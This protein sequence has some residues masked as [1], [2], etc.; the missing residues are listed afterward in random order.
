MDLSQPCPQLGAMASLALKLAKWLV[1]QGGAIGFM[2]L[3]MSRDTDKKITIGI[4]AAAALSLGY[5]I[6]RFISY[7]DYRSRL[8]QAGEA[9][10]SYGLVKRYA[11]KMGVHET[12]TVP[13]IFFILAGGLAYLAYR[14]LEK[15]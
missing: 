11:E 12:L 9:M 4:F 10:G 5:S 1:Y 13:I 7:L 8:A 14:R 6:Y 3:F 15:R 2:D